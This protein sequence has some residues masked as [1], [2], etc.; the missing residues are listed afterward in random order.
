MRDET[1]SY[2]AAWVAAM[3]GLGVFLPDRLRLVDDPFGLRFSRVF[4][5]FRGPGGRVNGLAAATA[6]LWFRGY[7]RRFTVYMQLRTRVIDD[8]I[9][10]FVRAGGRQVVLMGAGFDC[11]AWRLAAL[12]GATVFE[13]DHPATQG[14][15]R[16]VTEG[17][18][19]AGRVAFVPWNFER[20]LSELPA[21]LAREGHDASALTMTVLEGVLMYL[22]PE[23]TD[24]TFACIREY[25]A[26]G[27]LAAITYMD[28]SLVEERSRAASGRRLVV[29]LV[30]EPFR[31]GFEAGTVPAWLAKRGFHLERD[32]S[33]SQ[34]ATRYLGAAI[35]RR[36]AS[37]RSARSH[38]ALVRRV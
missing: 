12:S 36:I 20:P 38:F 7:I 33:A 11:R 8:D 16:A 26:P 6:R 3:R 35:G 24:A 30:G 14:K 23:A 4:R 21:R 10:D 27:S 15:K 5:G 18:P 32:E 13:V 22:T 29:R 34:I 37:H 31:N 9:V 1:P 25:S 17:D 2:T 19:P 28:K